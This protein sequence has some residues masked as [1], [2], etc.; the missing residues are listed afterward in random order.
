V[1]DAAA[2]QVKAVSFHAVDESGFDLS[3]SDEPYW[4]FNS[5]GI[6]GRNGRL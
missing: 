1:P 2:V 4:I 3:G 5:V 6:E